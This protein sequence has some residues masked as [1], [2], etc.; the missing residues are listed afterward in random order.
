VGVTILDP[1][2]LKW[3]QAL[4]ES[5]GGP[6]GISVDSSLLV[7]VAIAAV[8][9]VGSKEDESGETCSKTQVGEYTSVVAAPPFLN[10]WILLLLLLED[11]DRVMEE[12]DFDASLLAILMGRS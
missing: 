4:V 7:W 5:N 9:A 1:I 3:Q 10:S 6:N 12:S 8:T 11:N 2:L